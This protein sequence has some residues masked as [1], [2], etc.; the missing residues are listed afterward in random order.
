MKHGHIIY[1]KVSSFVGLVLLV[2]LVGSGNA[3]A[4]GRLYV[5]GG[6]FFPSD[7][8]AI[9]F[10]YSKNTLIN[11]NLSLDFDLDLAESHKLILGVDLDNTFR[12]SDRQVFDR[13]DSSFGV[14]GIDAVVGY[15]FV[16]VDWFNVYAKV[17]GGIESADYILKDRY[18]DSLDDTDSRSTVLGWRVGALGG[19]E[20]LLP[21][22]SVASWRPWKDFNFGIALLGGFIYRPEH[23]F[24]LEPGRENPDDKVE[25]ISP[26]LGKIDLQGG[27]FRVSLLWR[28]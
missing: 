4:L 25:V 8:E 12:D 27:F 26:V 18:D 2:L 17:L 19:V 16:V 10:M 3:W 7:S 23:E 5:G 6:S 21:E 20:F 13:Y 22:K 9:S 24:K 15:R 11:V 28:F 1:G 14:F